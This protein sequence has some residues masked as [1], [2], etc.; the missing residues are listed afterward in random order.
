MNPHLKHLKTTHRHLTK[1]SD[2]F[3]AAVRPARRH[4]T[5]PH[6]VEEA[7][8]IIH[9]S[10]VIATALHAATAT[11]PTALEDI[12]PVFEKAVSDALADAIVNGT[13]NPD[14]PLS[15]NQQGIDRLNAVAQKVH[16]EFVERA[17][18]LASNPRTGVGVVHA[19][20][21]KEFK[22]HHH[23]DYAR[24]SYTGFTLTAKTIRGEE[25]QP[26]IATNELPHAIR[27]N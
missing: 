16:D 15:F 14:D 19:I 3:I 4:L 6:E 2:E 26:R 7:A 1:A 20:P 9:E 23:G 17:M 24:G 21:F 13:C 8:S 10:R 27:F 18:L 22:E 5:E 12:Q 11:A 25:F